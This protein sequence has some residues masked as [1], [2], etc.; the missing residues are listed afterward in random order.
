MF[1]EIISAKREK[2]LG[3]MLAKEGMGALPT[4]EAHTVDTIKL[5]S[6]LLILRGEPLDDEQFG[7]CMK[8]FE[9]IGGQGE[10]G[11]WLYVLPDELH[12][13]LAQMADERFSEVAAAWSQTEEAQ[14]D[15]WEVE[16][17]EKFL[18]DLSS[19]AATARSQTLNLLL[20]ESL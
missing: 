19:F 15:R 3:A 4:L 1:Q 8:S 13:R 7:K 10:N 20:F 16:E 12:D 18:R 2:A 6:L 17:A 9:E 14:M 11:P 5:S